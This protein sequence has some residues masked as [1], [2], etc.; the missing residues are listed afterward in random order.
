VL[1]GHPAVADCRVI[2]V[3]NAGWGEQVKAIVEPRSPVTAEEL[4]EFCR[5]H[6][7]HDK[8]PKTIQF[9]EK[10]PRDDNGKIRKR[11]LRDRY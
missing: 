5:S 2:P 7:A 9:V 10:L 1:F 8:C 4:I 6:L 11:E 3:P